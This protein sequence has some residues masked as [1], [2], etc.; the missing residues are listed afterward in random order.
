VV[1]EAAEVIV[2]LLSNPESAPVPLGRVALA[3]GPVTDPA[4]GI[5]APETETSDGEV[6]PI[7]DPEASGKDPVG[8]AAETPG[9]D[10][11]A[12]GRPPRTMDVTDV[13]AP[14]TTLVPLPRRARGVVVAGR[15]VQIVGR[16]TLRMLTTA[17]GAREKEAKSRSTAN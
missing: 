7:M 12:E 3:N 15:L 13:E 8:R 11:E 10:A 6:I 4:L 16:S 1:N 17:E 14:L 5:G 2:G 9:R